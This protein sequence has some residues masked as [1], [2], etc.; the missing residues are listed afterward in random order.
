VG[1]TFVISTH[2]ETAMLTEVTEY[3]RHNQPY[4][5][6][7]LIRVT[8]PDGSHF[9]GT[10]SIVG[11]N[12]ILTATHMVYSPDHGGW[13]S[14]YSFYFGA[15]YNNQT[16]QFEDYGFKYTPSKWEV[17]AWPEQAFADSDNGSMSFT[18]TQYDT[19]L[20]GVNDAI[21]DTLGWLGMSSGYNDACLAEAVGYPDDA[22]GMMHDTVY[23][24][25]NQNSD[26]Y[27][28]DYM[29][30]GSGSSGGPLLMD[31]YVVGVKSTTIAWADIGHVFD[32][33]VVGMN[34]N[35]SLLSQINPPA[36][37]YPVTT[38]QSDPPTQKSEVDFTPDEGTIAY[39]LLEISNPMQ[40]DA[41]V[42]YST[43]DG[44]AKAGSDYIATSGIATINAGETYTTIP[45]QILEDNLVEGDETF[46]LAVTNPVNGVFGNSEVELLAQRTIHDIN[47][48]LLTQAQA[49]SCSK[50]VAEIDYSDN[51]NV[52]SLDS[53]EHWSDTEL[54]YSFNT[55]IPAEYYDYS[56]DKSL[57]DNWHQL[58][59]DE[60]AV[61]YNTLNF[62]ELTTSLS[63]TEV[64]GT[65][66]DLRFNVVEIADENVHSFAFYP[67]SD[68]GGDVF[69]GLDAHEKNEFSPGDYSYQS[70]VHEIGHA[71]GLKHPFEAPAIDSEY[72]NNTYTVMSYTPG[73]NS[74]PDFSYANGSLSATYEDAYCTSYMSYDVKALQHIYGANTQINTG[75][76]TYSLLFANREYFTVWDGGGIDTIDE[77]DASGPSIIN[78]KS[79][80]LSSLDIHDID[81]QIK[82]TTAWYHEQGVTGSDDWVQSVYTDISENLYTGENNFS[83]LPGV[84]IENVITGAA[85]DSV[86]DNEVDNNIATGGGDDRIYLTEG[87]FDTV[88][89]GAGNDKLYVDDSQADVQMETQQDGSILLLGSYFAAN[90]TGIEQVIFSD[91][92]FDIA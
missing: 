62:L 83:I 24:D 51:P 66:G 48:S 88:D 86:Y 33:L 28:S 27:T 82:Q 30:M 49:F 43:R 1:I 72:E 61:V 6:I 67:G 84:Y 21:G 7:G 64:P 17:I 44:S 18:E 47:N 69:I 80:S 38:S 53:G 41:S 32:D 22:T 55:S 74:F 73:R 78:L 54:T 26:V 63:F 76:D 4:S 3:D 45:V 12:D 9:K 15:D 37:T 89:G 40:V 46:Y 91:S 42:H 75:D 92:I 19:A 56:G 52:L 5:D 79:G 87:G 13:A 2:G 85:N 65:Q 50:S 68:I 36:P 20:V 29:V 59:S 23:I 11:Q 8:F 16:H 10:C 81:T 90:I 77:A 14:E 34:N 70:I 39:F 25:K 57:T 35:D 60:K 71:V 58:N 31:D